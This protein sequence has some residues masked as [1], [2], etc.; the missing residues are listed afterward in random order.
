MIVIS[1]PCKL[2][3]EL[4][5]PGSKSHTIRA[6]LTAAMTEGTSVIRNPLTSDDAKSALKAAADFGAEVLEEDGV[7]KVTGGPGRLHTPDNYIDAGNSGTTTYF[8]MGVASVLDGY[9]FITGD[10]QIRRRPA[11]EMAEQINALGG[12]AVLFHPETKSP[13]LYIRGPRHGGKC[14][15]EG[16]NSQYVSGILLSAPLVDGDTEV[17]IDRPFEKPYLQ[18]TLDWMKRFGVD[19]EN[20]GGRYDHF[21][22]KGNQSYK[23]CDATVPADWSGVAFPLMAGLVTGSEIVISGVDFEDSQGDKAVVD[24]MLGMGAD[25]TKDQAG[26]RLLVR[27]GKKLVSGVTINLQDT[28]DALP[29]LSVAAA[30]AEGDTTFTGL[31]HVRVKE[32]DRVAV[33]QEELSKM[34]ADI[35]I[36]PDYMVVHGGKP[37]HGATVESHGDHRIAMAMT[38][39]GMMAKG[40]TVV[41]G[42]ECASVSFPGFYEKMLGI[43]ADLEIR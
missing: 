15:F 26:R 42:A 21:L 34:G 11:V 23:A 27:G 39:A 8:V 40:E 10:E 32:T 17:F 28:P 14:R 16:K 29:A 5:V 3:G 30:F 7:W 9:T 25:L 37:L 1:K 22:V 19:C 18:L 33:M 4:S 24:Y 12:E 2:S 36:G 43:G 35:E 41:R 20:E 6:V 13:P 31:A 38:V